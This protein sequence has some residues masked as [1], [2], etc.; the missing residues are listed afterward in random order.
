MPG[1]PYMSQYV[2]SEREGCKTDMHVWAAML[3]NR[4]GY[5]TIGLES[6]GLGFRALKH[7]LRLQ[8]V[9]RMQHLKAP[10][11][12]LFCGLSLESYK[13]T[14]KRNYFGAHGQVMTP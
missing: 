5:L 13:V 10:F 14:P 9:Q 7:Y 6:P 2:A 4:V 1:Y 11:L 12:F 8:T 3:Q